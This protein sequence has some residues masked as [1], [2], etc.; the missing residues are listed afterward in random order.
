[1]EDE[2]RLVEDDFHERRETRV[3]ARSLGLVAVSFCT[4]G[5]A[6]VDRQRA[7]SDFCESKIAKSLS[8]YSFS[9][10]PTNGGDGR[11]CLASL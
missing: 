10:R 11:W 7:A 4:V 6:G 3:C 9:N 2:E 1:M 8:I 5:A